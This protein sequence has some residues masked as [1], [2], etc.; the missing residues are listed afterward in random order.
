MPSHIRVIAGCGDLPCSPIGV[1]AV[2]Y[3]ETHLYIGTS[4][5]ITTHVPFKKTDIFHNIASLPSALPGK[6][7]VPVEQENAGGSCL[8]YTMKTLSIKDYDEID[9]LCL[10]SVEG[11]KWIAILTL[12]TWRKSTC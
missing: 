11:V 3:Y 4:S 10:E 5:W 2:D 8:D 1:G 9:R 7:Y 6:Y 12:V